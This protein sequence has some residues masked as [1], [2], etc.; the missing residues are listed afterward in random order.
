[1][2]YTSSNKYALRD[3]PT[4]EG[5][6]LKELAHMDSIPQKRCAKCGNEYPATTEYFYVDRKTSDGLVS[7]CKNCRRISA[8]EYRQNNPE[9]ISAIKKASV[10]KKPEK[11]KASKQ[12]WAKA[13]ANKITQYA[14]EARLR[15]PNKA[16]A[17]R[18]V[19]HA[20]RDGKLPPVN[21]LLCV[22]CGNSAN[23][24]HHPD[25]SKPLDVIPLCVSCH[26]KVHKQ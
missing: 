8:A 6:K 1:M 22:H 23:E 2:W 13:N 19:T 14:H 18:V 16:K 3:V 20:V 11:Y 5:S 25:Y 15:Y 21:T 24:Y 7:P 17:R 12:A 9:K 4:S 10:A 26:K